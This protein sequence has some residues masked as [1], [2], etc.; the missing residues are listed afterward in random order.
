MPRRPKTERIEVPQESKPESANTGNSS[1]C[2][3]SNVDPF[4]RE[5]LDAELTDED[6]P[7]PEL[8]D[9]AKAHQRFFDDTRPFSDFDLAQVLLDR[10]FQ[11]LA[12][13]WQW[14]FMMVADES[15]HEGARLGQ[16]A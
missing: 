13:V 10:V 14:P 5:A 15:A 12:N 8:F 11:D 7:H 1:D 9:H 4:S 16:R 2:R 3:E 6:D